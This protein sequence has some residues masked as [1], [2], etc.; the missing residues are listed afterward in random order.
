MTL[1]FK[2]ENDLHKA[3][4]WSLA[5]T[6]SPHINTIVATHDQ[7]CMIIKAINFRVYFIVEIES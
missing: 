6:G 5:Y 2:S 4:V 1:N 3:S 7:I